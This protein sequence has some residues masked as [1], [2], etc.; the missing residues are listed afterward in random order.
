[1]FSEGGTVKGQSVRIDAWQWSTFEPSHG[2]I[3]PTTRKALTVPPQETLNTYLEAGEAMIVADSVT[4]FVGSAVAAERKSRRAA[5]R[6]ACPARPSVCH[7]VREYPNDIDH[8]SPPLKHAWI[9]SRIQ[10]TTESLQD[11]VQAAQPR[12]RSTK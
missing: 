10:R 6:T 7:R 11:K 5:A 12:S 9:R 2:Q 4:V 8:P 3:H 1:M